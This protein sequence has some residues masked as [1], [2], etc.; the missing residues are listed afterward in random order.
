MREKRNE[1]R[2]WQK[3]SILLAAFSMMICMMASPAANA[4]KLDQK[5]LV[6]LDLRQCEVGILFKEI[7][8]QTGLR[9]I[10]NQ[11]YVKGIKPFNVQAKEKKVGEVLEEVFN[12]TPFCC[13]FEDD[14]I[15][16]IPR[17][18]PES[19][20]VLQEQ[21]KPV[22]V[23]GIV[24]TVKGEP[25]PGVSVIIEGTT[26]GV[27][28][29]IDGNYELS[30]LPEG[31]PV[32]VYSFIG[33]KTRKIPYRGQSV[34]NVTLED[35]HVALEDVIVIG[36]GTRKEGTL[37][38]SVST[39][40][41]DRMEM[42]PVATL[43][44]ALQG[45][46]A[47]V[48][49]LSN[50]G[51]PGA[52]YNVQIR[53]VNSLTAG[54]E[55]LY[56]MDG[57]VISGSDLA[58]IN[59]ADIESITTLKDASSTSIYGARAA[60][61][62]IL[63]TSKRGR[64]GERPRVNFRSQFGWSALAYGKV[65]VM[66]TEERLDYEEMIG[67]NRE[68]H[69]WN[70]A[71]YEGVD[72]DWKKLLFND[73]APMSSYD[74]SVTGSSDKIS[75]Y[76]SAGYFTQEGIAPNSDFNR[77]TFKLNL[78]GRFLPWLRGG[79]VMTV[80]HERNSNVLTSTGSSVLN[81]AVAVYTML[82]YWN[83]Y[84]PDGSLASQSDGSFTR[85]VPNPL[86][87]YAEA[88]D[89]KDNYTKLVGS[90]FLELTPIQGLSLKSSLGVDAGDMRISNKG[91]PG[92][93]SNKGEGTVSEAF[94]R[95]YVLTLTNTATYVFS[96]ND[97]HR[98]NVL[99]GQEAIQAE[100]DSF[101]GTGIGLKDNRQMTLGLAQTPSAVSGGGSAYTYLSWFGRLSYDFDHRYFLDLSVRGDASSRFGEDDRWAYFWSVGAM[102]KMK[103]ESFLYQSEVVTDARLAVSVGT[104]GNSLIGNYDHM[105]LVSG[106]KSYVGGSTW[107]RTNP[108]N[109]NLSWERLRD[110][111]LT[112]NLGFWNRL[113]LEFSFY[114]KRTTNM[115]MLVPVPAMGGF[116]MIRDN[117][118]K[119]RN[120]G[121]EISLNADILKVEDFL[122]NFI[123]N[124]SYNN[125]KILALYNDVDIYSVGDSGVL[126]KVGTP[127]GSLQAVRFAGVNPGNG[128]AMW[129][130]KEG[131][132]T[133][134]YTTSD[135]VIL[136]G[137][138]SNAPWNGGFTNTFSWRGLSLSVFF[139][140]VKGR[141]M[142]NNIRYFTESNGGAVQYNQSPKM[143]DCWKKPGDN[144]DVPRYGV[145]SEADDRFIEDASFLRLK[146][147]ML[148]YRL[149]EK[150]MNK[151]GFI[152]GIQ[153][154]GQAQNL[155]TATKYTGMDPESPANLTL[156]EY[157][158]TKQFT[159]GFEVNF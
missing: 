80:G 139:N 121:I 104:S 75:Y 72:V 31:N 10:Y 74:L 70:R 85:N 128:D 134:E 159:F 77:Y 32:L 38:G 152:R 86:E 3:G 90:F 8:R 136:D 96:L 88:G 82:P 45:Q 39:V 52:G 41:A 108:G 151:T 27:S 143:L 84:R 154:F 155:W 93:Y 63:I 71:D 19:N 20:K 148:A 122:W 147:I 57:V 91:Y 17:S 133:N 67:Y 87:Y 40:K 124:V 142:Y 156:G 55:P 30:F 76:L 49:I 115:L 58:T 132:L 144:T 100:S 125:N 28:T 59:N 109:P 116:S 56:I 123:G 117:V 29:N 101:S 97:R 113:N 120:R 5:Q 2:W 95:N 157:P 42:M 137:K 79:G 78:D 25:L 94:M 13:Q 81:P 129:Y 64:M 126:L 7:R 61:G 158:Q 135:E 112:L 69:D 119:M 54:T 11:A 46:S 53:G 66:N 35:D 99:A 4:R 146:N 36:Y 149:P 73:N 130:D 62:V 37:T 102:W 68:N 98:F 50:S 23:K 48:Q 43:G 34:L 89:K 18:Q 145:P 141:Y 111:N 21:A 44:Q 127:A 33:M 9:F 14:V 1:K 12:N 15:Y 107:V 51:K 114:D 6:T 22:K 110:F 65:D 92:Y 16:I 60:N 131:K 106:A 24:S 83:P 47:G 138:S 26:K 103:E 118:G 140:W 153:V 105:S 150:W